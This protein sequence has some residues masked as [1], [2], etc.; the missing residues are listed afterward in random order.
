MK[1]G[2]VLTYDEAITDSTVLPSI[3]AD[4]SDAAKLSFTNHQTSVWHMEVSI[5]DTT[6]H[7][8]KY[9]KTLTTPSVRDTSKPATSQVWK[10][11]SYGT[12]VSEYDQAG[13][14]V[15]SF[16][17]PLDT[18]DLNELP[19]MAEDTFTATDSMRTVFDS[20]LT[21]NGQSVSTS[22]SEI[23]ASG[24]IPDTSSFSATSYFDNSHLT[25]DS[26]HIL[27][28]SAPYQA[29]YFS[30]STIGAYRVTTGITDLQYLS[31]PTAQRDSISNWIHEFDFSALYTST[32]V[33]I[34]SISNV[35]IP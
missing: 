3:F 10:V 12:N 18:D 15:N 33:T 2:G 23:I 31:M 17:V 24:N 13:D 30:Y 4:S 9:V 34:T 28:S 8:F 1:L 16:T 19:M 25:Q 20:S 22:G 35:S 32:H 6:D 11:V 27:S 29:S 26:L 14:L 5:P 21:A 7:Y